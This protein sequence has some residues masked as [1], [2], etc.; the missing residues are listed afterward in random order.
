MD[1]SLHESSASSRIVLNRIN[2]FDTLYNLKSQ[3]FFG[4]LHSNLIYPPESQKIS[5]KPKVKDM[6]KSPNIIRAT[7]DLDLG[8]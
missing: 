4:R 5:E 7:I 1:P 3:S 6:E 8:F 2:L